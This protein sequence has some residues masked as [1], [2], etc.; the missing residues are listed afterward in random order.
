[1]ATIAWWSWLSR[2]SQPTAERRWQRSRTEVRVLRRRWSDAANTMNRHSANAIGQ[3]VSAKRA[4]DCA[5][6]CA[7]SPE[8]AGG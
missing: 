3:R 7:A 1:V 8:H 4:S 5:R 2:Y 6:L